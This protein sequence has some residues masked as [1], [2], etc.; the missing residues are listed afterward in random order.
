M[1]TLLFGGKG[2]ARIT[3]PN[4]QWVYNEWY[5][6]SVTRHG[7]LFE[8]FRN[9]EL[10]TNGRSEINLN[11]SAANQRLSFGSRPAQYSKDGKRD[12]P[13][14]GAIDDIRIYDIALNKHQLL[15]LYRR[16]LIQR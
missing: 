2:K 14:N 10:V 5:H 4:L 13:W 16:E 8:I 11:A 1:L 3:T 15:E 12:H 6:V 7:D 9:G